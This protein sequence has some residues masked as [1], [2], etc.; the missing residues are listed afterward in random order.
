M[1]HTREITDIFSTFD[2]IFLVFT[3]KKINCLFIF[4]IKGKK[5]SKSFLDIFARFSAFSGYN[6]G[7]KHKFHLENGL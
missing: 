5:M 3:R 2:E 4:F 7:C 1:L 6:I